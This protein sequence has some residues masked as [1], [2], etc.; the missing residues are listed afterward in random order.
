MHFSRMCHCTTSHSPHNTGKKAMEGVSGKG[1]G[2]NLEILIH[3]LLRDANMVQQQ[4]RISEES[5]G[6]WVSN[7][8][9]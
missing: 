3:Y 9:I 8:E 6:T 7:P 5:T 4:H 1:T 2:A